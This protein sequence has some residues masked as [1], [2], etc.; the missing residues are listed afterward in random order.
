[1]PTFWDDRY[2]QPEYVYG[3]EPNEFLVAACQPIPPG[4][5]L[6]LGEGEGRNAVYLA[7]RGFAVTAV[8]GSA[9]G[10]RKAEELAAS[11]GVKLTT[12]VADLATYAIAP[13]SWDL[14]I[15]IFCHLP[16]AIR[17]PLYRQVVDGLRPGGVLILEAYTPEQ[18]IYETGGPR[19]A[20]MLLD[21]AKLRAEF[22]GLEFMHE[23]ELVRDVREGTF[24]SG[25][26][27]VVQFIARKP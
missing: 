22:A 6:S 12:V 26:A 25:P 23:R 18:L 24:H 16:P 21:L 17:Q 7:S 19:D 9:V 14:M 5:A 20:A 11:R 4:R 1:M 27:A 8:D 13:G 2:R 15:S 10:L 3:T